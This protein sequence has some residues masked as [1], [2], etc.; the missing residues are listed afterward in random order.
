MAG[1]RAADYGLTMPLNEYAAMANREI[2]VVSQVETLEAVSN[3]EE[4]LAVEGIDV[5]FIGPTDL[6]ASMGYVGQAGH[7]DVQSMIEKLARR[8]CDAGKAAGTVAYTHEALLKAKERG[9]RFI[10]HG[11][12][13]MLTKSGREY[14]ELGR[15]S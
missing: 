14:L 15:S 8:I 7:A 5:F 11:L 3:L 4:M 10:V 9:F 12:T 6:S 13:A 2:V 1:V